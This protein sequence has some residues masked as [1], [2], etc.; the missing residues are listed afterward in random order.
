MDEIVEHDLVTRYDFGLVDAAMLNHLPQGVAGEPLVPSSLASS[1]HL[2]PRLVNLRHSSQDHIRALLECLRDARSSG[3]PAP[4]ALLVKTEVDSKRFKQ[5]WNSMQLAA[6]QPKRKVWLRLH[7]PRVLHQL[8]RI[9]TPA[10]RRKIFT[11]A[12]VFT[13][14]LGDEWVTAY[15]PDR[16]S[17]DNRPHEHARAWDWP[18]IERIGIVNRALHRAGVRQ[19]DMLSGQGELAERLIARASARYGLAD[20]AD[21]IEFAL[22]GLTICDTFDECP[23]VAQAIK[24]GTEAGEESSLSD[25]FALIEDRVWNELRQATK[26]QGRGN[27]D[28]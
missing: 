4:I 24:P 18:R 7:D 5:H 23:A 1:V 27:D 22:R 15:D 2:M 16:S 28:D 10:Q 8:L 6:P 14:W 25:R 3:Q 21:L 17:P 19:A 20:E 26:M 11:P 12:G 9:L 13:Y